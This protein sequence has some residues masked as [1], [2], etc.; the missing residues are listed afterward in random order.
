MVVLFMDIK[1]GISII[2]D[3]EDFI[4]IMEDM[5]KEYLD[6]NSGAGNE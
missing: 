6:D 1:P 3:A 2:E 4:K 5:Q